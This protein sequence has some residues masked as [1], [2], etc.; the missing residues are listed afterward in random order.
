MW[1]LLLPHAI[2]AALP[3]KATLKGQKMFS[4]LCL[5]RHNL[6]ARVKA[7]AYV[8]GVVKFVSLLGNCQMLTCIIMPLFNGRGRA[9]PSRKGARISGGSSTLAFSIQNLEYAFSSPPFP[10]FLLSLSLLFPPYPLP[11]RN[12]NGGPHFNS[13]KIF[14]LVPPFALISTAPALSLSLL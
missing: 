4:L 12:E 8:V 11:P 1:M 6:N 9:S 13:Q 14:N 2:F 5:Q 10:P 7:S 3:K